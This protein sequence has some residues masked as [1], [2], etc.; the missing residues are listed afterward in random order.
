M[1]RS[2][3]AGF[4]ADVRRPLK[5]RPDTLI[6][7]FELTCETTMF[8]LFLSLFWHDISSCAA[9]LSRHHTVAH[10]AVAPGPAP[11]SAYLFLSWRFCRPQMSRKALAY[12]PWTSLQIS[13][14]G[15]C[16][17]DGAYVQVAGCDFRPDT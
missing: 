6:L 5:V 11:Q 14:M 9:H 1:A 3:E 4:F 2:K 10:N 16:A 15:S 13:E 8:S 7:P 17:P 12:G